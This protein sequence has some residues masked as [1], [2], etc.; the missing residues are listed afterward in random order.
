VPE[1]CVLVE[2]G[3]RSVTV[4]VEFAYLYAVSGELD[5]AVPWRAE[6][7]EFVSEVG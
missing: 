3:V 2:L 5:Q 1:E 7:V 6:D 4:G